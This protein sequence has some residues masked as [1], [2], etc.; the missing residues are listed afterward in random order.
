MHAL[1]AKAA[2]CVFPFGWF[3][4]RQSKLNSRNRQQTLPDPNNPS[5]L[6]KSLPRRRL[7]SL[8]ATAASRSPGPPNGERRRW[9]CAPP[10]PPI[11][12]PINP[13]I[14][15]FHSRSFPS[16]T[17]PLPQNSA[18]SIAEYF[19]AGKMPWMVLKNANPPRKASAFFFFSFLFAPPP[20]NLFYPCSCHR[21]LVSN[22]QSRSSTLS[23]SASSV[24]RIRL[25][26][27]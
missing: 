8:P 2:A 1:F 20:H 12:N 11:P 21:L 25:G 23:A 13:T 19:G 7:F 26:A 22:R 10:R 17:S 15:E 4:N 16:S 6:D 14:I 24:F 3:E 9:K 18:A 5:S 27:R